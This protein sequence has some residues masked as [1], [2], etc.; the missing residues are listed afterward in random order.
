MSAPFFTP[1]SATSS[2]TDGSGGTGLNLGSLIPR[3]TNPGGQGSGLCTLSFQDRVFRFRTNP[4][5]IN[6]TYEM[7]TN[8]EQTYGGQVIQLL[9][10]RLGDLSVKVEIGNAGWPYLMQVVLYLRD[11]M[12][13][14][15]NGSVATF[16]YTTRNWMLNVYGMTIPFQDS[17]DETVREI[18]LN[19]KI[20]EDVT[21]LMQQVTL[22]VELARL[23]DG[24]YGPGSFPHNQFNDAN[25][26]NISNLLN[27]ALDYMSPGGPTYTPPNIT[28]TVDST[29]EGSNPGG[30]DPTGGL[31]GSLLGGGGGLGGLGS[32]FGF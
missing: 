28:N 21:G 16:N 24:V 26:P 29:P 1:T 6:W 8:V 11:L 10:T 14:Q 18:E 4:N 19:F 15:R 22:D 12:S 17:F 9:G 13:D 30:L 23:Q 3:S 25:A 7:I 31:L 32:L 2:I 27:Q 20:Q 5:T